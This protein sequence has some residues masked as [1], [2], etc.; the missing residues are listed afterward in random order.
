LIGFRGRGPVRVVLAGA[1]LVTEV[2]DDGCG[3]AAVRAG[4]GLEGLAD[5]LATLDA[6]R[7]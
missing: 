6:L 5:R 7:A 3:G 4:S 2:S 1:S